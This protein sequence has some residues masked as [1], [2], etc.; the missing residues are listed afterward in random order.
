MNY[1]TRA[2]RRSDSNRHGGPV[3]AVGSRGFVNGA[4]GKAREVTLLDDRETG[5]VGKLRDGTPVEILA[6]APRGNATRYHV[7]GLDAKR[8]PL[9]GWLG[10]ACL[11]ATEKAPPPVAPPSEPAAAPEPA[12]PP[13]A[14][15]S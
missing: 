12:P 10:A 15:R 4:D 9:E 11:R 2:S 14:P 1:P 13:A 3:F 7:R 6:W 5:I 8:R